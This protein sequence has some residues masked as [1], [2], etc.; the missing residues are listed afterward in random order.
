SAC[1]IRVLG[2]L[3]LLLVLAGACGC[4]S[5]RTTAS[6]GA[7]P[8]I[9]RPRPLYTAPPP[10]L[11]RYATTAPRC[12][13]S[14]LRVSRGRTGVGLGNLLEQLVFTNIGK[15]PC[16]LR[17]YPTITAET[18]AGT[19]QTVQ[20]RRGGTYFGRLLPADLQPGGRVLL[21]FGTSDCGCRCERPSPV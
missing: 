3:G 11:D 12:R 15:R 6:P 17:G 16:L 9:N 5:A 19:R 2:L 10:T 13:A 4:G 18:P 14:Q 21:D 20:A 8:W 1:V 7:V